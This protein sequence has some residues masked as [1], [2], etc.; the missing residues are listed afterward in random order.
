MDKHFSTS[1]KLTWTLTIF[2]LLSIIATGIVDV[3]F[4]VNLSY[5]LN[6]LAPIQGVIIVFYFGKSGVENY[7]KIKNTTDELMNLNYKSNSSQSQN[8]TEGDI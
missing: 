7:L 1:K 5:L 3:K 8:N 6:Y 2:F 4:S